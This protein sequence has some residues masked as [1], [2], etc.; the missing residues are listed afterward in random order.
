MRKNTSPQILNFLQKIFLSFAL[1]LSLGS[2]AQA[3]KSIEWVDTSQLYVFVKNLTQITIKAKI[4]KDP[5]L[6][7]ESV[8][9]Y[10]YNQDG[11]PIAK[12]ERLYDDGT[13]GDLLAGNNT[14]TAQINLNETTPG[15]LRLKVTAAYKGTPQRIQSDLIILQVKVKADP[16]EVRAKFINTLRTGNTED[17]MNYLA[18]GKAREELIQSLTPEQRDRFADWVQAAKLIKETEGKR[19][20]QYSIPEEGIVEFQMAIDPEGDWVFMF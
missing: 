11:N 3:V 2:N 15:E 6:I 20:Y 4:A 19:Y 5:D 1:C 7:T 14:F 13:H 9:L 17:I 10:K 18:S 8:Y 12:I 16:E